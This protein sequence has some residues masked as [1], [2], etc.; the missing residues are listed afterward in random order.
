MNSA[1]ASS[2]STSRYDT[3]YRRCQRTATVITSRGKR[4]PANAEDGSVEVT[5]N[6]LFELSTGQRNTASV[7]AH[8]VLGWVAKASK[9]GLMSA[10]RQ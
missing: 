2:F 3:P 5:R 4:N 10:G 8:T 6:S 1:L 7:S 9:R